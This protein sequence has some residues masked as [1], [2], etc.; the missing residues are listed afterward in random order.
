MNYKHHFHAGGFSDVFKHV[1]LSYTLE[2]LQEKNTPLTYVDTHA[3]R[4]QYYLGSSDAKKLKEYVFGIDALF[5]YSKHFIAPKTIQHYIDAVDKTKNNLIYP[6]SP[7]I[8]EAFMRETDKMILSELQSDEYKFLK[9]NMYRQDK[10]IAIHHMDAYAA[11][12][13]FLPPKTPR[14][15][16]MID[17][18][19]EKRNEFLMLEHVL[20]HSLKHWRQGHYLIWYPIK[21]KKNVARFQQ[22]LLGLSADLVC[23][24]FFIK[25]PA[26]TTNLMGCGMALINSPWKLPELL[27]DEALPYLGEALQAEWRMQK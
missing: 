4:G 27:F 19:F 24:D 16:V 10:R 17:P 25:N 13:A 15:I 11:M 26:I 2:K 21:D 18:S 23:I 7:K 5:N 14:G 3:G 20:T 6:G 8:A 1:V 12:K 22:F 9:D